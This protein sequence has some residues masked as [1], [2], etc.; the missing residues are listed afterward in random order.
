M[1]KHGWFYVII[2]QATMQRGGVNSLLSYV[3]VS[4]CDLSDTGQTSAPVASTHL[5]PVHQIGLLMP[6]SKY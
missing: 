5:E 2:Q 4:D 3:D 1:G 6:T